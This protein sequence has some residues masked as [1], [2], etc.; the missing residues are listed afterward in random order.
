MVEY[1]AK[2]Q[3]PLP[4][5]KTSCTLQQQ[6]IDDQNAFTMENIFWTGFSNGDR[7]AAM[8]EISGIVSAFGD[9]VNIHLFSDLA[10]NLT[11]E[12]E[13]AKI[14][15]LYD[16]LKNVISMHPHYYLHSAAKRERKVYLNIT[17]SAG[18]GNLRI[19]VPAVPG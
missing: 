13:E 3:Y 5:L 17:F 11:I 12:I 8:L 7:P 1:P 9:L 6:R 14:D 2:A 4:R 15:L 19:E 18:T 10:V 16:A